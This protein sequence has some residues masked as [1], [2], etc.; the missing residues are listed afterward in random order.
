LSAAEA[1]DVGA[2]DDIPPGRSAAFVVEGESIAVFN[3]AGE[4]FAVD[5]HCPH[6][7]APLAGSPLFKGGMVRCMMHGW[8]F[9]LRGCEEDDGLRRYP[10]KVEGGRILINPQPIPSDEPV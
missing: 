6:Q 3:D 4:L 9:R 10:V 2:A 7:D 8:L 1:I 5:N